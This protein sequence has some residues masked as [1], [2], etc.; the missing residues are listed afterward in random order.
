MAA[1]DFNNGLILGMSLQ[2]VLFTGGGY[3]DFQITAIENNTAQLRVKYNDDAEFTIF[4][5]VED[6][7]TGVIT[8]YC[9][10]NGSTVVLTPMD[11]SDIIYK[12]MEV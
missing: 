8:F 2:G 9:T 7:D 10:T 6:T 1:N 3:T 12:Q 4:N 11:E 5:Y